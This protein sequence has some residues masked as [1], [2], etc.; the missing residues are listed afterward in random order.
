MFHLFQKT[1]QITAR[2]HSG[3]IS[4]I[5]KDTGA[6]IARSQTGVYAWAKKNNVSIELDTLALSATSYE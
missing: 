3:Y 4:Y 1:I 5:R 6:E 2:I